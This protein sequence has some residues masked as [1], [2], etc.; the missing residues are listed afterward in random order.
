M[1]LD[2]PPCA[3][4]QVF[5]RKEDIELSC[6]GHNRGGEIYPSSVVFVMLQCPFVLVSV[7]IFDCPEDEMPIKDTNFSSSFN[8][9]DSQTS[10]STGLK[11]PLVYLST[12]DLPAMEVFEA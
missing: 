8:I 4:L 1:L 9:P 5:V 10:P 2:L 6:T 12:E 7:G 3:V 11:L